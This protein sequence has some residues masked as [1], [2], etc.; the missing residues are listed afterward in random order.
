MNRKEM[1]QW[2]M[3]GDP[4]IRWWVFRDLAGADE[5]EVEAERNRMEHSGKPGRWNTQW[6]PARTGLVQSGS[7]DKAWPALSRTDCP[8]HFYPAICRK[9]FVKI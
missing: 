6:A 5:T 9:R 7:R 4:A 2:L 1:I 3:A 8:A